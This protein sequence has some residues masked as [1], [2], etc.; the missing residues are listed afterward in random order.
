VPFRL[1]IA[2]AAATTLLLGLAS[3][4]ARAAGAS[5]AEL[6]KRGLAECEEG[7]RSTV[8]DERQALFQHGQALGEQA[9]AL[10][11]QSAEA[12]FT[13]FC[14]MGELMRLDGETLS[15]M[16]QFRRL[17]AEIDRALELN[18]EY[19]EALAAKGILLIRLPR[20]LGGD[21]E[22]GEALLRR[23]LQKDPNAVESRLTLAKTCESRGDRDEAVAFATRALQIAREQGRADKVA[24]AQ[25]TLSEL[26]AGR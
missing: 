12:H 17:N 25:A 23:V 24:E 7:R 22:R 1:P 19:T 14:N 21:A 10:D 16:L 4:A 8:R 2:V 26:H 6:A 18:P 3:H 15:S 11:P 20:L 13:I 9:V 5:A